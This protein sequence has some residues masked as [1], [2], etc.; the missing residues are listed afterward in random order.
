MEV[1]GLNVFPVG[2]MTAN[3]SH[4]RYDVAGLDTGTNRF[5][6][7][8]DPQQVLTILFQDGNPEQ[9]GRNGFTLESLLEIAR[10]RLVT[11]QT[12]PHACE[13]SAQVIKLLTQSLDTLY[14]RGQRVNQ[15]NKQ[16]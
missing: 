10:H 11:I 7:D 12:G 16:V 8:L 13:E 3:H 9:V 15:P 6:L 2:E 14:L 4:N 1:N 5:R